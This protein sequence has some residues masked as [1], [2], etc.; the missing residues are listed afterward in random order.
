MKILMVDTSNIDEIPAG[1]ELDGLVAQRVMGWSD[2]KWK[3]AGHKYDRGTTMTWPTGWIGKGPNGECYLGDRFSTDIA[4]AWKVLEK[5]HNGEPRFHW[6]I[7]SDNICDFSPFGPNNSPIYR[8][9]RCESVPL[10]ICRASLKAL[11]GENK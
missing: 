2:L 3:D 5:M 9:P 4:A 7:Y 1:R 8:A 10:A 11:E 6:S